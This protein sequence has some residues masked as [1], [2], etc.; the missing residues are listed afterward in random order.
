M[1][2]EGATVPEELT[3]SRVSSALTR[4]SF[5]GD[6]QDVHVECALGHVVTINGQSFRAATTLIAEAL[7]LDGPELSDLVLNRGQSTRVQRC[8]FLTDDGR[9]CR[10]LLVEKAAEWGV[11]RSACNQHQS[12][13][14]REV[15]EAVC[16]EDEWFARF[17]T[18]VLIRSQDKFLRVP[19]IRDFIEEEAR[20]MVRERFGSWDKP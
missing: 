15:Q 12:R 9:P 4:R 7:D 13:L 5:T 17:L 3:E 8:Q 19:A 10:G 2:Q 1:T 11:K 16:G 18:D 14:R 20:R 6:Y